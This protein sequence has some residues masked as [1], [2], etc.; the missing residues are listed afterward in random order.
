MIQSRLLR[1]TFG[2]AHYLHGEGFGRSNFLVFTE[3]V[4]GYRRFATLLPAK[5]S[6]CLL[7]PTVAPTPPPSK[8]HTHAHIVAILSSSLLLNMKRKLAYG[9]NLQEVI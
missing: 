6:S 7:I 5:K 2:R 8:K 1:N 4:T 9:I 3:V